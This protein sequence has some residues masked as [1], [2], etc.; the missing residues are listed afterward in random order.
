MQGR[1]EGEGRERE[2]KERKRDG[3]RKRL[4]RGVGAHGTRAML[5]HSLTTV[6]V[7][8]WTRLSASA[9]QSEA[10][11]PPVSKPSHRPLPQQGAPF[12]VVA[13]GDPQLT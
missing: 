3:K 13:P 10:Q 4:Y 12:G 7:C 8:V 5:R 6:P 2:E 1:G 9:L 11:L